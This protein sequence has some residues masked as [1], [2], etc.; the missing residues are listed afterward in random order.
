MF[1]HRKTF[2]FYYFISNFDLLKPKMLTYILKKGGKKHIIFYKMVRQN[3]SKL[4]LCI[5]SFIVFGSFGAMVGMIAYVT[6]QIG[7]VK[8]SI[9]FLESSMQ[10]GGM[11]GGMAGG[12]SLSS[13]LDFT[14]HNYPYEPICYYCEEIWEKNITKPPYYPLDCPSYGIEVC[15]LWK[16]DD[17]FN[18]Q[19]YICTSA[20]SSNPR[21][22]LYIP[23]PT[24]IQSYITIQPLYQW[25]PTTQTPLP[26]CKWFHNPVKICELRDLQ[27]D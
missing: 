23:I 27:I 21:D 7:D 13:D 18:G 4:S 12:V 26:E 6:S 3:Y 5:A 14:C 9:S 25:N 22:Y 11:T 1:F 24:L 20:N 8:K 17:I 10:T 15:E 2:F 16:Y 19:K